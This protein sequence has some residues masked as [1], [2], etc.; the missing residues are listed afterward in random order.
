[1]SDETIDLDSLPDYEPRD[2]IGEPLEH[3]RGAENLVGA[4]IVS[5]AITNPRKD[6]GNIWYD[7]AIE[8]LC[9]TGRRVQVIWDA[10]QFDCWAN[11]IAEQLAATGYDQP[12]VTLTEVR[13][14]TEEGEIWLRLSNNKTVYI[15]G[16]ILDVRYT[17]QPIAEMSP[18]QLAATIAYSTG[19][20]TQAEANIRYYR[21]QIA[22]LEEDVREHARLIDSAQRTLP[23]RQP[24]TALSAYADDLDRIMGGKIENIA[25]HQGVT[26]ITFRT[27]GGH[28]FCLSYAAKPGQSVRFSASRRFRNRRIRSIRRS[29][30]GGD[31]LGV[32]FAF[33]EDAFVVVQGIPHACE[34]L[35]TG[36]RYS[37][38]VRVPLFPPLPGA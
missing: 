33:S 23:Y 8:F 35:S 30:G 29:D 34:V 4:R 27:R 24:E 12:G 14:D 9:P 37:G 38:T 10:K 5:T 21:A 31:T 17:D 15:V 36:V 16:D 3:I 25:E 13:E 20:I 28:Q 2:G 22:Q 6:G 11:T 19:E 18:E 1:M 26:A 32:I 7:L